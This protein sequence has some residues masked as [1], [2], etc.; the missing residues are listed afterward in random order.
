MEQ[1]VALARRHPFAVIDITG[2]EPAL[3][4]ELPWLIDNLAPLTPRLLLRTNLITFAPGGH[5]GGDSAAS[6]LLE[7]CRRHRAVLMGSLPSTERQESDAQRGAGSWQRSLTALARLNASGYGMPE[8]GLELILIANPGEAQMPGPQKSTE[9]AFTDQLERDHGLHITRLFTLGNAPIG[10][11]KS[12][13]NN[14]GC[15]DSYSKKL[16]ESFNPLTLPGLMCRSL[17]AVR[18]DGALFDCDFNMALGLPLG[19]GE[20]RLEDLNGPPAAGAP[21]ALGDHCYACTAG[22]GFT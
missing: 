9:Q 2:G 15:I 12:W 16:E 13:L 1:V 20:R 7:Q 22:S 3:N 19:S 8:R 21:L 5:P 17:L 4:P 11:H 14:N 18:W 10:R 6:E